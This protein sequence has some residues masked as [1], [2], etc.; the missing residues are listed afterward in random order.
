M[1]VSFLTKV[2]R[3]LSSFYSTPWCVPSWGWNE[4]FVTVSCFLNGHVTEGSYSQQFADA[5]RDYTGLRYAIPVNRGRTAIEIAL[6][7]MGIDENTEVVLPSYICH[8]VP[9]AVLKAGG[10]PVFA[11]VGTD[12]SVSAETV[13]TAL[14]KRTKCVIVPHLFGNTAPIDMIE[15]LLKGTGIFLIDDAAQSF[16]A[17]RSG[18][19]IGTFGDCGII[20]CGPAKALAGAAGGVLVTNNREI[21]ERAAKLQLGEEK[22]MAV[23]R[24]VMSFWIWR[25]FRKFTLPLRV[26]LSKFFGPEKE[27]PHVSCKMSNL[28]A[29]IGLCQLQA[30]SK[31]ASVRR[32]NANILLRALGDMRS[33]NVTDM[34]QDNMIVK[35]VMVLPFDGPSLNEAIVSLGQAGIECQ[36]GYTPCHLLVQDGKPSLPVTE[37]LWNRVL[38][39]PVEIQAKD[40]K[41][42]MQLSE[43]WLDL[44][45]ERAFADNIEPSE[46]TASSSAKA[47]SNSTEYE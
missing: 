4:F 20:S 25:R 19:L 2:K 3:L 33:C 23:A 32:R 12:L 47:S 24:R 18:R 11:D 46:K 35:L 29:A 45:T 37:I 34:A 44:Q 21:Y 13:R 27:Q 28:D 7:A 17:K 9:V 1:Q 30:S 22:A 38:C 26:I 43:N 10:Q 14:T 6:R 5:I 41:T 15:D 31:N 8:E 16:G 36:G 40:T 42:I 39:V